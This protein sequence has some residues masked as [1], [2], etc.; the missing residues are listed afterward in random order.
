MTEA[1]RHL[2]R[3][4]IES[5]IMPETKRLELERPAADRTMDQRAWEGKHTL[6]GVVVDQLEAGLSPET[7]CRAK[8]VLGAAMLNP[9]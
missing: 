5:V 8:A 1:E 6:F 9:C 3:A 2:L 7:L 4:R